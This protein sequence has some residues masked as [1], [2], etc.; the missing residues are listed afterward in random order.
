MLCALRLVEFE[1]AERGAAG[2]RRRG[3]CPRA[4]FLAGRKIGAGRGVV[5]EPKQIVRRVRVGKPLV[6][7]DETVPDH[8]EERLLEGLRAGGQ[9]LLHRLLHFADLAFFDQFGNVAAVQKALTPGSQTFEQSLFKMIR[10]GLI[11]QDEGLSN[12]DSA[13]NLLWLINNT[14]AGADF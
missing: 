7:G 3:S 10:D 8:F 1:F 5:D 4:S 12:A 11:T 9:R 6:L 2:G 14:A 13:N